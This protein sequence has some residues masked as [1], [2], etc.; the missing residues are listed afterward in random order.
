MSPI[1]RN[2]VA[3]LPFSFTLNIVDQPQQVDLDT[4]A[5]NYS[6]HKHYSGSEFFSGFDWKT[7][8]D[9]THGKVNYVSQAEAKH[10][11]LSY[12]SDH[13]T[14]VMR[15]DYHH[16]VEPGQRGRDSVRIE[17]KEN[18]DNGI[19]I[20]D[21]LHLPSG[22]GTWPAFWTSTTGHWPEGGEIDIIEGVNGKDTNQ[23]TLHTTPGCTMP[24][25]VDATGQQLRTDCAVHGNDNQGCGVKDRREDSFGPSFNKDQGGWYAMQRSNSGIKMWFWSRKNGNVPADVKTGPATVDPSK[26]G[27]PFANFPSTHCDMKQHFGKHKIIINNSLCG[28]WA[29]A[30][31]QQ[32]GCPLTCDQH[33][34]ND[35]AAFRESYWKIRAL[36]V[37]T[38]NNRELDYEG[39]ADDDYDNYAVDDMV[40][41][42]EEY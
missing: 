28:D 4:T 7:F 37:Y 11:N 1:I 27:K 13:N 5:S 38:E 29:G 17:S 8:N 41:Y 14:F 30:V 42:S 24:T 15:T 16:K 34:M 31:Y 26:W 3:L 40:V 33:V 9:P 23:G 32:Q 18:F 19:Y 22:C 35:P 10:K 21:V 39:E 36:R 20:L 6:L 2:I 12:V 25:N